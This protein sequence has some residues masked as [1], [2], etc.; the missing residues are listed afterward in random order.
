[1]CRRLIIISGRSVARPQN[2]C[3]RRRR[4]RRR[5]SWYRVTRRRYVRPL[6]CGAFWSVP[7]GNFR[8]GRT[9]SVRAAFVTVFGVAI[10]R[11]RAPELVRARPSCVRAEVV[12]PRTT[13]VFPSRRRFRAPCDSV[14][15][16]CGTS[17]PGVPLRTSGQARPN[18]SAVTV[19]PSSR[20]YALPV[21]LSV[22][23]RLFP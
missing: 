1:M 13:V 5:S 22:G 12:I 15:P 11:V 19:T 7:T 21:C 8:C 18:L 17:A 6:L 10:A 20:T 16:P 14:H 2:N 4:R 9:I 3:R 23:V